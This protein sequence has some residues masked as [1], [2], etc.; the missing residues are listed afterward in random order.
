MIQLPLK[1]AAI[2]H[3]E[4]FLSKEEADTYYRTL[5]ENTPWRQDPITLFGKTY[6]QPRLTAFYGDEGSTYTYSK[7]T[8][9]PLPFSSQLLSIRTAVEEVSG[10]KFNSV[11][12]NYYRDGS[13]SMG[14]HSDDEKELGTNPVIASLSLGATRRFLLRHRRDKH[15][16]HEISLSHGNLLLMEGTTQHHWQHQIPKTSRP[17]GGR[18]NLTFRRIL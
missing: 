4:H 16:K 2:R 5:R 9:R 8:M 7:L 11:L 13:D 1:D 14:W 3:Q 15:L 10:Y 18:I 6:L 12:I 17:M